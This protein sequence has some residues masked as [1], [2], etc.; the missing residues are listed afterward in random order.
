MIRHKKQNCPFCQRTIPIFIQNRICLEYYIFV[1]MDISLGN[2]KLSKLII[3]NNIAKK[4]SMTLW[5]SELCSLDVKQS[6]SEAPD[7][8]THTCTHTHC[9]IKSVSVA[10]C[11]S[12][13][14]LSHKCCTYTALSLCVCLSVPSVEAGRTK[15]GWAVRVDGLQ[16][17]AG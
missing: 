7:P 5:Q 17:S 3:L 9:P 10:W 13:L 8:H 1:L 6:D 4:F 14:H 11:W 16:R 15:S 12:G 2:M